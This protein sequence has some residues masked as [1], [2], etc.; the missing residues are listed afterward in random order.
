MERAPDV[1][2][3][4]MQI[5]ADGNNIA[6]AGFH[7]LRRATNAE[8]PQEKVRCALLGL[9][10]SLV[11][12]VVRGG[13]TPDDFL[14]TPSVT[15]NPVSGLTV[16]FDEGRPLRR[17][18]LFPP[19]QTGR[20]SDPSFMENEQYVLA[21]ISEFIGAAAYLPVTILRGVNTEADDLVAACALQTD[22][23]VR[24]AST[25]R[26]FLQLV[27]DRV[28]IYSPVKRLVV[29]PENFEDVTAPRDSAG[30]P[31]VFPRERYLDYR[32]ASGDASDNLPGIPGVGALTAAKLV[33]KAPIDAYVG[34]RRLLADVLGRRNVKVEGAFASGEAKE[35][36]ERN[37]M[38]MDLRIAA[39]SYA[40]LDEYRRQF[41]WDE[42]A[43][44][45]WAKD[46]RIAGMD[47]NAAC[48]MFSQIAADDR[49]TEML[50]SSQAQGKLDFS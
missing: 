16:V 6:W 32:V 38:L 29:T 9:T 30:T 19:Y 35:T 31:S 44:R 50:S 7:S 10:Q 20:E 49:I 22:N 47:L 23:Y 4:P 40:N 3:A 34:D 41:T 45:S 48:R 25:D 15:T 12:L 24:I 42:R 8:S 1:D 13:E 14:H 37:R 21:G 26:D 5:I 11:G 28:T 17:R 27:D 33:A 18:G 2:T 39:G 46:Q 36:I 43:F